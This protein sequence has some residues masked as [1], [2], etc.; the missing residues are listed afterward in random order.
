MAGTSQKM[1]EHLLET[2]LVASS[3]AGPGQDLYGDP[4][5][6]DFLLTHIVFMPTQQLVA[7]LARHYRIEPSPTQERDFLLACKR[8][9]VLFVNCWVHT[10]RH[11]VFDDPHSLN[12]LEVG[13]PA[14]SPLVL[15]DPLHLSLLV[16]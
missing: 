11:P 16:D 13:S 12:F 2:R 6:E 8:R 4:F 7:E 5:L 9:V 14:P 1:L 10:V 3:S 15:S